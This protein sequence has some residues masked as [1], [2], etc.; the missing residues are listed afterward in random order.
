MRVDAARASRIKKGNGHL[1]DDPRC[2]YWKGDFAGADTHAECGICRTQSDREQDH[3]ITGSVRA[4]LKE[5]WV[6][7]R[8]GL[9]RQP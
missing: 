7:W 6:R 1:A 9:G 8:N 5:A 3:Q 2:R 4:T